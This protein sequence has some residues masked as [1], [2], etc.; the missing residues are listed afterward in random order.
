MNEVQGRHAA[1]E[2]QF[3][4]LRDRMAVMMGIGP[5]PDPEE[6]R[7]RQAMIKLFPELG[8]IGRPNPQGEERV[9]AVESAM[10]TRHAADMSRSAV[11]VYARTIG[12]EAKDLGPGA[13]RRLA[14]EL[15]GFIEDDPSPTGERMRRYEQAPPTLVAEMISD[16]TGFY[17]HPAQV[18]QVLGAAGQVQRA[19]QLPSSGVRTAPVPST[20]GQP[21][22]FATK[23][24][25]FNAM[26]QELLAASQG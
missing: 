17:V 22:T 26:R 2:Q 21:R 13:A 18:Q 23:K 19:R 5:Q 1:L 20:S 4:T 10:W 16:L 8:Q 11:Q 9:N 3:N 6:Q 24:E 25:R 7:V 14:R 15:R 12:K